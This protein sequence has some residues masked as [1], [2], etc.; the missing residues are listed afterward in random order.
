MAVQI[1]LT[2]S[3]I[4]EKACNWEY[5]PHQGRLIIR[6]KDGETYEYRHEDMQELRGQIPAENS[7]EPDG[8]RQFLQ[9]RFTP[10]AMKSV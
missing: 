10:A 4:E 9:S 2:F 5:D 8:F 1:R 6:T 7:D 3:E